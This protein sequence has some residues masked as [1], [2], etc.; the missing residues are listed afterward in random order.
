MVE[1]NALGDTREKLK[2][3][4]A[5][6]ASLRLCLARAILATLLVFCWCWSADAQTPDVLLVY[7]AASLKNALDD[8]NAQYERGQSRRKIFVYYGASSTLAKDIETGA[9][10]DVFISADLDWMDYLAERRL[11]KP[12]TRTNFLGN[13]LVLIAS[14]ESNLSLTIGPNFPLARVLGNRRLAMADPGSV[15][16]GKYGKASL[17]ALG[18]WAD[19]A[20]RIVPARDV[21]EALQLVSDGYAPLGIVYQTDAAADKRVRI[22]GAFPDETHPPIVYPLAVVASSISKEVSPYIQYL[23]SSAAAPAFEKQGFDVLTSTFPSSP[24]VRLASPTTARAV[25]AW[26]ASGL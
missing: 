22:V 18:V 2:M 25:K 13:K 3:I 15:P 23:R 21:R 19:V 8:A 1:F 16:A 10:A 17:E 5:I 20:D 14:K 24:T 12:D 9:P 26:R 7:G 11:I 4:H 6:L